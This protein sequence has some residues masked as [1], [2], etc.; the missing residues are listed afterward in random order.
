MD[1]QFHRPVV[2][3]KVLGGLG[4]KGYQEL[5]EHLKISY[6]SFVQRTTQDKEPIEEGFFRC[7]GI[8]SRN[9]HFRAK[10]R[11]CSSSMQRFAPI[12]VVLKK[13]PEK[14]GD[15]GRFLIPCDFSEFDS[16]LALADLGASINLMPLFIWKSFNSQA[17][18]IETKCPRVRDTRAVPFLLGRTHAFNRC[19][20]GEITLRNDD[21]SLNLNCGDDS[22]ISLQQSRI[23]EG[24]LI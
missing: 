5:S 16:Y 9:L 11:I 15:P 24:K 10:L 21:Q 22:S 17:L 2:K 13:L 6:S 7:Y 1:L 3:G 19:L 20:R 18:S 8:F 14:L 12:A 23:V 4:D